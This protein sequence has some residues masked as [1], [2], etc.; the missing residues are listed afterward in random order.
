VLALLALITVVVKGV[1][2]WK[3]DKVAGVSRED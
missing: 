3:A 1:V 2:E